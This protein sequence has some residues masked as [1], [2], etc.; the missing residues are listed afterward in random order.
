MG[1]FQWSRDKTLKQWNAKSGT[2]RR[3]LGVL[4]GARIVTSIRRI[5]Q[6]KDLT[7]HYEKWIRLPFD[8]LLGLLITAPAHEN[9]E[10]DR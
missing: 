2:Q 1:K 7:D 10:Q 3:A 4:Q 5:V 6:V 9:D 8:K